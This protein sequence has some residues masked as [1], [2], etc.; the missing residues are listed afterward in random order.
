[1]NSGSEVIQVCGVV[2]S[3]ELRIPNYG[4][5]NT[6]CQL[7][8]LW[9][10]AKVFVLANAVQR[11]LSRLETLRKLWFICPK[12]S[13]QPCLPMLIDIVNIRAST[14]ELT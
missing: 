7:P 8:L 12:V 4:H 14:L 13:Q 1:M 5:L 6:F 9:T 2:I 11:R 10:H 3:F